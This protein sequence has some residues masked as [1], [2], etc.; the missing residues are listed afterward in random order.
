MSE[1]S[2]PMGDLTRLMLFF[3]RLSEVHVKNLQSFP[4]IYFNGVKE[5]KLDYSIGTK[6][7]D[8]SLIDFEIHTNE[9]NDLLDKRF[10]GLET[11]V[12]ALFWKEIKIKAT[13]LPQNEV[14]QSE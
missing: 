1:E 4:F 3:G 8:M 9:D 10:K 6:R 2:S 12:R 5:V 13:L 14:F 11:A 7:D